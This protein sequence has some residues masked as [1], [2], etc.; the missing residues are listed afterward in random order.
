MLS[1]SFQEMGAQS[2]SHKFK[3]RKKK[4]SRSGENCDTFSVQSAPE[5]GLPRSKVI[6][7][8]KRKARLEELKTYNRTMT[9]AA[10]PE[11]LAKTDRSGI[12][13]NILNDHSHLVTV[14]SL[15]LFMLVVLYVISYNG[16]FLDRIPFYQKVVIATV[17]SVVFGS[18]HLA[19]G[20]ILCS[21]RPSFSHG[22]LFLITM[23]SFITKHLI[24]VIF[25]RKR[26]E[27]WICMPH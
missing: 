3:G 21:T 9:T 2:V 18:F 1:T 22:I 15:F 7:S 17:L 13:A 25:K 11:V 23:P 20:L 6:F 26:Q 16:L 19:I 12:V 24:G 4:R 5:V 27:R 14:P 8:E 10:G